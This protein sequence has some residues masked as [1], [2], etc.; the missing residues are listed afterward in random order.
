METL[1][2]NLKRL[3]AEKGITQKALAM[4]LN[5]S[6][7]TISNYEN[8]V[9]MPDLET[10]CMLA[11]FYCVSL[12]FLLGRSACPGMPGVIRGKYTLDRFARLLTRLSDSSRAFLVY[13][14]LL[15][16]KTAPPEKG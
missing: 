10:L 11:D 12:D 8:G 6:A 15:L 14:L 5:L 13:T 3:R 2:Q 7:G 4:R 16:E 1:S 9:H